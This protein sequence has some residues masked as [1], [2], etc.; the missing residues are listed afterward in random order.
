[1]ARK[2]KRRMQDPVIG[3]VEDLLTTDEDRERENTTH[4]CYDNAVPYESDGALGHGFECGICGEF[5]QAG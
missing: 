1:M 3:W 5:L 2:Q 4:D